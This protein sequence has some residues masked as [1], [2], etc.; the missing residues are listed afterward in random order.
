MVK[1]GDVV[2]FFTFDEASK[3]LTKNTRNILYNMGSGKIQDLW[4]RCQWYMVTQKGIQGITPYEKITYS[5]KNNWANVLDEK[6]CVP[7]QIT[8]NPIVSDDLSNQQ[9][10][11]CN[12][13][14]DDYTMYCN[15]SSELT[16]SVNYG[17]SRSESRESHR[18]TTS[19]LLDRTE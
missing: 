14:F 13:T 5:H 8:G 19:R 4:Y 12:N 10:S 7:F 17:Y 18:T 2:I 9:L 6:L 16:E 11:F 3:K 15:E 1:V